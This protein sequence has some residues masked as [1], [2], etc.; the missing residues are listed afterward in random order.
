MQTRRVTVGLVED[1]AALREYIEN[2][3]SSSSSLQLSF[4][5]STLNEARN[6]FAKNPT[7]ICLTDIG[8]PDGSGI[9]FTKEVKANS[10]T[11]IL[12]LTVLG[13]RKSVL[14]A[15]EAGADGYLLK[16]TPPEKLIKKTMA[17]IE[18]A[19]P[20]SPQAATHLL[21]AYTK[22]RIQNDESAASEIDP[23]TER[24]REILKLFDRGLSYRETADALGIKENTIR[25][26]V[27]AIYSK[28][29]VSSRSEAI[30]E[31]RQLFLLDH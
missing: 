31:A 2:I 4:S 8:L 17:T 11:K 7:D 24:E 30:F 6:M 15:L 3:I 18:G 1:D 10:K 27:K 29:N 12:I 26:H 13:D 20:I 5:A 25:T 28:L 19:T 23:L 9:D 21:Q 14:R 16:D 22:G